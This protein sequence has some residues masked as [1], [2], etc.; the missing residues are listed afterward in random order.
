ML[1]GSGVPSA[2][3]GPAVQC[4]FCLRPP[5][6]GVL[7]RSVN[8][9]YVC[10]ECVARIAACERAATAPLVVASFA[11]FFEEWQAS[12]HNAPRT[13]FAARRFW[14]ELACFERIS[15]SI[16]VLGALAVL[17]ESAPGPSGPSAQSA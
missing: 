10:S 6:D 12:P 4:A 17:A 5:A 11:E 14:S 15:G 2:G 3:Y 9:A 7:V 1:T 13:R 8:E 16:D